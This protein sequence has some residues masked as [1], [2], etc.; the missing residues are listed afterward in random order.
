VARLSFLLVFV[1]FGANSLVFQIDGVPFVKQDREQC[2]PASLA[3][4]FFYYGVSIQT[5]V[6]SKSIYDPKLRGS[7]ITDLENFAR[8]Q[9]F[10]TESGR[11]TVEKLKEFIRQRKPVIVLIDQGFWIISRPH[12][13]VLFGYNQEGF[14]AHNGETPSRL[15]GYAD[16]RKMWDKIGSTYLLVYK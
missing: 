14:I 13:L 1:A 10:R 7:L 6:I 9:G 12:Y 2:G 11:G 3:S 4:V 16:F 15:Y 8:R 5:D